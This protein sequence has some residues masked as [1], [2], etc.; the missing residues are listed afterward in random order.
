MTDYSSI[1]HED[2]FVL[3]TLI[4]FTVAFALPAWWFYTYRAWNVRVLA[5]KFP[6][7]RLYQ[8]SYQAVSQ[9]QVLPCYHLA[10]DHPTTRI[11]HCVRSSCPFG[12]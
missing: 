6:V 5:L 7:H 3:V 11:R 10:D 2:Q 1:F 12:E 9:K 4:L 8:P